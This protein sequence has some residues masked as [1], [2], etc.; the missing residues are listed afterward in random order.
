MRLQHSIKENSP[1]AVYRLARS[2]YF[3]HCAPCST[4]SNT[5]PSAIRAGHISPQHTQLNLPVLRLKRSAACRGVMSG[6]PIG[7]R[8]SWS[9]FSLKIGYNYTRQSGRLIMVKIRSSW[10][11]V[12]RALVDVTDSRV[13]C[14]PYLLLELARLSLQQ[15]MADI[16][17]QAV[18]HIKESAHLVKVMHCRER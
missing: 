11:Y 2:P 9:C 16:A 8:L 1:T 4:V 13:Y 3:N 10:E 17:Q 12:H 15:D 7:S 14:R 6:L 5:I 18:E